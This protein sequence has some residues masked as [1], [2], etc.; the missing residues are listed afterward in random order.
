MCRNT[1]ANKLISLSFFENFP[2][3]KLSNA[4]TTAITKSNKMIY[5]N[6]ECAAINP[7]IFLFQIYTKTLLSYIVLLYYL[8]CRQYL[9]KKKELDIS[10]NNKLLQKIVE[11]L[12]YSTISSTASSTAS[13]PSSNASAPSSNASAPSS[14]VSS[15]VSSTSVITSSTVSSPSAAI[16]ST[17]SVVSSTA[18]VEPPQDA[19]ANVKAKAVVYINTFFINLKF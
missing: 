19:T 6:P 5:L 2:D 9:T 16:S 3:F 4:L 11:Y 12:D 18:S 10:Q 13:A 14:K 17:V 1:I 8:L 7:V 15:V